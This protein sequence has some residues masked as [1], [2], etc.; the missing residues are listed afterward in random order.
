MIGEVYSK[1]LRKKIVKKLNSVPE[2]L[3]H[4]NDLFSSTYKDNCKDLDCTT[5]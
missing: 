1:T 5:I 4:R 3:A 2:N